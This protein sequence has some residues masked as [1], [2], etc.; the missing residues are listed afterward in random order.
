MS[1]EYSLLISK[2]LMYLY[3]LLMTTVGLYGIINFKKQSNNLKLLTL[4][5]IILTLSE[6]YNYLQF[7]SNFSIFKVYHLT[8]PINMLLFYFIFK[9]Y[10]KD[11]KTVILCG[12]LTVLAILYSIY[13][14]IFNVEFQN[15]PSIGLTFLSVMSITFALA[16]LKNI[17]DA[18]AQ[19]SLFIKPEFWLSLSV[20]VFYTITYLQLTLFQFYVIIINNNYKLVE[21]IFRIFV[22]LH[23]IGFFLAIH[24]NIK[25]NYAN[26]S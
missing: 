9:P 1:S 24:Y 11:K 13:N 14:S 16:T 2:F 15:Y 12:V 19:T 7:I 20:L 4:L 22:I 6:L 10:W 17:I 5:I 21:I 8:I 18:P 26:R 25:Q 3:Y 23:Y